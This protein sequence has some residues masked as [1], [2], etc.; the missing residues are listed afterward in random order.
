MSLR[1]PF[2]DTGDRRGAFRSTVENVD[3]YRFIDVAAHHKRA[4]GLP[5]SDDGGVLV[6][7]LCMV[8]VITRESG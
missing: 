7:P 6:T 8:V 3:E 1:H 2:V 5:H 4:A